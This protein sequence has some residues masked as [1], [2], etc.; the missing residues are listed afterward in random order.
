[1]QRRKYHRLHSNF[2]VRYFCGNTYLSG[3]VINFSA[4][5]ML[6]QTKIGFPFDW[7]FDVII[8][9]E[10]KLIKV[11]VRLSR[12]IRS[13]KSYDAMAV[14]VLFPQ[15]DYM[16]FLESLSPVYKFSNTISPNVPGQTSRKKEKILY[17]PIM[18]KNSNFNKFS[19]NS[20]ADKYVPNSFGSDDSV[21]IIQ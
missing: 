2:K 1:M 12:L 19:F 7:R 21:V 18:Q 13:D 10:K 8:F 15:K 14:K 20:S 3:T 9:P 5:G 16:E 6:I 17:K 4:N 11:P